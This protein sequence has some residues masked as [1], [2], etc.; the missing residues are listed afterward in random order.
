LISRVLGYARDMLVADLFGAKT[1]ADAFFVAFRIPNL[2]RRLTAEGAMTAAFVPVYTEVYE[3]SGKPRAFE[4]ACNI[5][6]LLGVAL[7]VISVAGVITAPWVVTALAPG[8]TSSEPTFNL[9]TLLTRIMFPYLIFVSLAAVLMAMQNS[10]GKFF[11]PAAAPSMLNIAIITCALTM[12]DWF[13]E[14]TVALAVGVMIGGVL[15]LAMQVWELRRMG[16]KYVP[17]FNLRDADAIRIGAL[18]VPATFGM[19]VAE[20]NTFVDTL[21]ASFLPEGSV[22]YL[23]YGNRLVQFPLGVFGVAVGVAALPSLS[24]E[25]ARGGEKLVE[26]FSH[27]MRLTLFIA[28]PAMV[29]LIALSGPMTNVLFERGQFDEAAR[30]GV[31]SA[32]VF[33]AV[34]LPAFAATKIVVGV[35]YALKDT[36]APTKVAV[37]CMLINIALNLVLMGPL[38]HGGLAL[39]TSISA[40]VNVGAL[41]WMLRKRLGKIDG[42]RMAMAAG[43]MSLSS[44]IMGASAYG[45]LSIFYSY[46]ARTMERAF[47]L[48]VAM[49]IGTILYFGSMLALG[50]PEALSFKRRVM[51][52]IRKGR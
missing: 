29:G 6:T 40:F 25:A 17:S 46:E 35:F 52:K 42:R 50:S 5:V 4:L 7:T 44:L 20:I 41:A 15:Q 32:L 47:H 38:K 8:F 30:Y 14:P 16:W 10:M 27:S 18:M 49:G 24:S 37:W 31:I 33:Y 28:I 2:L 12:R 23:Y 51:E 22:S 19:A 9:T 11:V 13:A 21:I 45:Y 39:A 48:I 34:G 43:L 3:K 1:A 26:L 36:K